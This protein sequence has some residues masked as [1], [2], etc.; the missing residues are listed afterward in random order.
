[1]NDQ[2]RPFLCFSVSGFR[3]RPRWRSVSA[4]VACTLVGVARVSVAQPGIYA[5][6]YEDAVLNPGTLDEVTFALP[7]RGLNAQDL[8]LVYN[9]SQPE[10]VAIKDCYVTR[11]NVPAAN[12]VAVNAPSNAEISEPQ[13]ELIRAAL[14]TA[15]TGRDDIQAIALAWRTPWRVDIPAALGNIQKRSIS[16]Y[17]GRLTETENVLYDSATT[18]PWSDHGIRPVMLITPQID[19]SLPAPGVVCDESGLIARGVQADGTFPSSNGYLLRTSDALRSVRYLDFID[20]QTQFDGDMV[21]LEYRDLQSEPG[22]LA[23]NNTTITSF[24]Q[25]EA[26]GDFISGES[27]VMF[28]FTGLA[29]VPGIASNTFLPGSFSDHL[30]SGAGAITFRGGEFFDCSPEPCDPPTYASTQMSALNWLETGATAS[31]GNVAEPFSTTTRYP[32]SRPLIENYL[33]GGT[34]LES[35]VK[36]VFDP[37]LGLPI[38]EP[39]ARAFSWRDTSIGNQPAIET[40][41]LRPGSVYSV[42]SG[43]DPAST[44]TRLRSNIIVDGPT[45]TQVRGE[46]GA[47]YVLL[48]EQE[49]PFFSAEFAREEFLTCSLQAP[50]GKVWCDNDGRLWYRADAGERQLIAEDVAT[51]NVDIN[52]NTLF[53]LSSTS[54]AGAYELYSLELDNSLPVLLSAFTAD[55]PVNLVASDALVVWSNTISFAFPEV[56]VFDRASGQMFEQPTGDILPWLGNQIAVFGESI[57]FV[58]HDSQSGE[59]GIYKAQAGQLP[60]LFQSASTSATDLHMD[61]D[62]MVWRVGGDA[63][64][65][66]YSSSSATKQLGNPWALEGDPVWLDLNDGV[67]SVLQNSDAESRL[68]LEELAT[69]ATLLLPT[70][71]ALSLKTLQKSAANGAIQANYDAI[72][73]QP[74]DGDVEAFEFSPFEVALAYRVTAASAIHDS[75]T[76]ISVP[77]GQTRAFYFRPADEFLRSG[78]FE[79]DVTLSDGSDPSTVGLSVRVGLIGDVNADGAVNF[80]DYSAWIDAFLSVRGDANYNPAADFDNSGSVNFLDVSAI[81]DHFLD[82]DAASVAFIQWNTS[83]FTPGQTVTVELTTTANQGAQLKKAITLSVK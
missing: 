11:R 24:E 55:L 32:N 76:D 68:W 49:D 10:S 36:S 58:G 47:G 64:V 74:D 1:M 20:T 19:A 35:V 72:D 69:Q 75:V 83:G 42:W 22:D 40:A 31:F 21:Q 4:L 9:A 45:V 25:L 33:Y 28:H 67:V 53:W 44:L 8:L 80:L 12:I 34:L 82:P 43:D 23:I 17:L 70:S 37:I 30:T 77:S 13:A 18:R 39:L 48:H 81:V 7:R 2:T 27:D 78:R 57:A 65:S 79:Y 41:A 14:D 3:G 6:D 62:W 63:F 60:S 66:H 46:A 29:T 73:Y 56:I 71:R 26:T 15:L 16:T 38:G 52:G 5:P 51:R 54:G 61:A 50:D 59:S